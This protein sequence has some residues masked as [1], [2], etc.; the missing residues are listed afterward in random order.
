MTRDQRRLF[1]FSCFFKRYFYSNDLLQ[2]HFIHSGLKPSQNI[3][4]LLF[5]C[6]TIRGLFSLILVQDYVSFTALVFLFCSSHYFLCHHL[7]TQTNSSQWPT[8]AATL[9]PFEVS[10][11]HHHSCREV[12]PWCLSATGGE[13]GGWLLC[14]WK[15]ALYE[16]GLIVWMVRWVCTLG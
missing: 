9:K 6:G 5:L 11:D 12:L 8:K 10:S 1:L 2:W 13:E 16:N 7:V 14:E 15:C 4:L 3:F